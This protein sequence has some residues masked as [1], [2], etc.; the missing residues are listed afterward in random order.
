MEKLTPHILFL[1]LIFLLSCSNHKKDTLSDNQNPSQKLKIILS[2]PVETLDPLKIIYS[3]DWKV[4]SNIFEGLVSINEKNEIVNEL[5][6]SIKISADLLTY[7]FSLK[8]N[9]YFQDSPCFNKGAGRKLNSKDIVYTFKRLANKENN[10]SNWQAI[11]DKISGIKD[12]YNKGSEGINGIKIIDSLKFEIKLNHPFS[13]FLKLL[14]SPNFYIV[15]HEAINY[16]KDNFSNHPVGTGPFRIAEQKKYEK[17]TLVRNERYHKTDEHNNRLPILKSIE[18]TTIEE[19]ENKFSELIKN[20]TNLIHCGKKDLSSF[21]KDTLLSNQ[22]NIKKI[23][24][25]FGVRFWSYYYPK[26]KDSKEFKNLRKSISQN[27]DKTILKDSKVS[28]E[29]AET[30]VP[31]FFFNKNSQINYP[32]RNKYKA[33]QSEVIKDTVVLMANLVYKELEE[34]ENTLSKLNVPFKRVIIPA[35]YYGEIG[36]IKPTMFRVSMKPSYPDPV[37]YYSLFYS[38]NVNSVNLGNF[39]NKNYDEIYEYLQCENNLELQNE[40]Y[41]QLEKI[42]AEEYAAIYLTHQSTTNYIYPKKLKKLKFKY[43]IPDFTEAYFD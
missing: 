6:K 4:A 15:P 42:L 26:G 28:I 5:V 11:S 36:K 33:L 1:A 43:I 18:Y 30:L 37:E 13:S 10:F 12:Y 3:P 19:S 8:N 23:A 22:F 20:Q 7:R 25:T 27:F 16:Y 34:L 21:A 38:K 24:S 32:I 2:D 41:E 29:D 40:A 39:T 14:T 31:R 35:N 17:I 9:I